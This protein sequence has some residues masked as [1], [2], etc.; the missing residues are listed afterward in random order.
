VDALANTLLL[1][2][3]IALLWLGGGVIA[4]MA[5]IVAVQ[6]FSA[7][8]GVGLLRSSRLL[9]PP[10]NETAYE[11]RHTL[12]SASPLLGLS[13][14]DVLQQRLDLIVL[15]LFAGVQVT[16]LYSVA[17]S[18]IRVLTKLVQSYWRA[19]LPTFARLASQATDAL[20]GLDDQATRWIAAATC[21]AAA[22]TTVVA[23]PMVRL[24]FGAEYAPAG[25]M[26]AVLV[27]TAPL[28]AVELRAITRLVA[29]KR[30]RSALTV[31]SSPPPG[32]RTV[33]VSSASSIS[34]AASLSRAL[35]RFPAPSQPRSR[36]TVRVS[37]SPRAPSP[38]PPCWMSPLAHRSSR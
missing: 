30:S 21:G 31:A 14:T 26:L 35:T 13:L 23:T 7:L 25:P 2:A 32:P 6:A 38:S 5:L 16:G 8:L 33:R 28:Y 24:I 20:A 15:G 36:R 11:W 29:Q 37:S 18:L 27:W 22:L 19:L 17:N 1:V 12:R 3:G 9:Q 4:L 10:Q 34:A